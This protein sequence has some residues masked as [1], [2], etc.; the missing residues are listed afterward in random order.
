LLVLTHLPV[1]EKFENCTAMGR[2]TFL[3]ILSDTLAAR[4]IRAR[5]DYMV[6]NNIPAQTNRCCAGAD[7][8]PAAGRSRHRLK[9]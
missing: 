3:D 6:R 1:L 9:A 5:Q 7:E 8:R 2:H 4:P